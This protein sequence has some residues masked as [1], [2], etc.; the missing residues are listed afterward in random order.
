MI[1]LTIFIIILAFLSITLLFL[2][3]YFRSVNQTLERTID[4]LERTA[5]RMKYYL[6]NSTYTGW[7]N[8]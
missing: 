3:M 8:K 5:A 1:M 7:L 4:S 2:V 6:D